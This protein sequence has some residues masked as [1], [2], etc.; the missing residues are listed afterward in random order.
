MDPV[1][2]RKY[3]IDGL[4]MQIAE[5]REELDRMSTDLHALERGDVS[6]P[7]ATSVAPRRRGRPVGS[8]TAT[9][10]SDESRRQQSEAMRRKW[11]ER[12]AAKQAQETVQAP[13]PLPPADISDFISD[14]ADAQPET[15]DVEAP[16][17]DAPDSEESAASHGRL[18]RRK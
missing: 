12:K 10:R 16:V 7:S 11:A 14:G 6:L 18:R 1:T 2:I 8:G 15:P 5:K 3:A 13:A 9:V 17:V 4:R